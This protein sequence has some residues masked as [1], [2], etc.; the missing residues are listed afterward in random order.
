MGEK[1]IGSAQLVTREASLQHGAI[2]LTDSYR[3]I[4]RYLE[5][6]SAEGAAPHGPGS[7]RQELGREVGFAEAVAAFREGFRRV[8]RVEDSTLSGRERETAARLA[9]ERYGCDAWNL[10]L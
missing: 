3:R 7:L 1:L 5:L 2:P 10:R 8:L 4:G 6:A 9:A